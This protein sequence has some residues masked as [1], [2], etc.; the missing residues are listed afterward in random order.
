MSVEVSA[1]IIY[2]FIINNEEY[3]DYRKRCHEA[4]MDVSD[5][6]WPIN[7]YRNDSDAVY[8]VCLK[9]TEYAE[10][11]YNEDL[12]SLIDEDKWAECYRQWCEDFPDKKEEIP[13]YT[14]ISNWW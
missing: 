9:S 4:K 12:F 2:G 8:G 14:L 5:Y 3:K 11:I 6:C 13:R 1:V 10:V 7:E